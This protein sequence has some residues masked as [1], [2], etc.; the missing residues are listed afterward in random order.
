MIIT[1]NKQEQQTEMLYI[2][3]FKIILMVIFAP[4][5]NEILLMCLASKMFINGKL[6]QKFTEIRLK[7]TQWKLSSTS[8]SYIYIVWMTSRYTTLA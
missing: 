7:V 6:N 1:L 4:W 3:S 5:I 8:I 2:V